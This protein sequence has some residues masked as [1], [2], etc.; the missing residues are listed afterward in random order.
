MIGKKKSA[1]AQL[2]FLIFRQEM[3]LSGIGPAVFDIRIMPVGVE[4]TPRAPQYGMY[5][6]TGAAMCVWWLFR[7]F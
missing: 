3:P 4:K 5:K 2:C 1:A 6:T 7:S